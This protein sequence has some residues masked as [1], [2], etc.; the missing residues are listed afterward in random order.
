MTKPA[1]ISSRAGRAAVR[2]C[3][4]L[5]VGCSAGV[6]QGGAGE[7]HGDAVHAE[8]RP[9]AWHRIRV[10]DDH[11]RTFGLGFG[12]VDGDGRIDIVSGRGVYLNPGGDLEGNWR[13]LTLPDGW[14]AFAV[15][16][17]AVLDFSGEG[18]G[19]VIA[20]RG[21]D[22][23]RLAWF[24]P[25]GD[26]SEP[27]RTGSI[28]SVPPA[29]H[30]EGAQGYAVADL[31]AGGR[32]QVVVSSGG[33][34]HYFRVPDGDIALRWTAVEVSPIPSDEGFAV[35]DVD[36]DGLPD[37]VAPAGDAPRIDWY[38]N[39]GDGSAGWRRRAVGDFPS[40]DRVA[41]ADLD[42]DGRVEVVTTEENGRP[43]GAVTVVW[44]QPPAASTAESPAE[45]Q[46]APFGQEWSG[47]VLA[48]QGSTHSLDIG[49]VDGDGDADIV[50]GE[51][52]GELRLILWENDGAG[53]FTPVPID[54][55]RETHLG[56]RL[57]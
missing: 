42:G 23:L 3:L 33:G 38:R 22:E 32:P 1:G 4:A 28:G 44:R 48:V 12:D 49:D 34:I 54:R 7:V 5:L 26:P 11:H 31:D 46:V 43:D 36:G 19:A 18:R 21:E 14:H 30:Q 51:H 57:A 37:I 17:F 50:T 40:G 9:T 29:E 8:R 24:V 13:V 52:R 6:G 53:R 47:K 35:A 55:G 25:G 56:A 27:W 16:D 2:S 45:S 20:Q 41:A 39:P 10:T 15:L